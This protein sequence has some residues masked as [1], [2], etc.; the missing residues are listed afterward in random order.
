MCTKYHKQITRIKRNKEN[1]QRVGYLEETEKDL[2][3]VDFGSND[4]LLFCF[5]NFEKSTRKTK[6]IFLPPVKKSAN[7]AKYAETDLCYSL[8]FILSLSV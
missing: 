2:R 6:N 8:Y 1:R 3:A 7:A 4:R 5:Q